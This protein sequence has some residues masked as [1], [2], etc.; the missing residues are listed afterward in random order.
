MGLFLLSSVSLWA[1]I[2]FQKYLFAILHEWTQNTERA[3]NT[4]VYAASFTSN[5]IQRNLQIKWQKGARN[6]RRFMGPLNVEQVYFEKGTKPV[7]EVQVQQIQGT[8]LYWSYGWKYII[9]DGFKSVSIFG[10]YIFTTSL[11][12]IV[13]NSQ[14]WCLQSE[15]CSKLWLLDNGYQFQKDLC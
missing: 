6:L 15:F 4:D 13:L 11:S 14:D 2:F 8:E 1:V 10:W 7:Q 5:K 3:N 9:F 12:R